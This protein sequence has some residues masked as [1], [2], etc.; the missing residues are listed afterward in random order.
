MRGVPLGNRKFA[1]TDFPRHLGDRT[2][3]APNNTYDPVR[4]A[5]LILEV[6]R[7]ADS[8]VVSNPK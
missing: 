5:E 8:A 6:T 7:A 3:S 4:V 1:V 2:M